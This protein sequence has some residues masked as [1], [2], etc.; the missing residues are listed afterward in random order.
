MSSSVNPQM[1]QMGADA[2]FFY[3]RRCRRWTQMD[4][5]TN[6]TC[7]IEQRPVSRAFSA[8]SEGTNIAGALPQAGNETAPLALNR[9]LSQGPR[10]RWREGQADSP[11]V[12]ANIIFR[13]V[14]LKPVLALNRDLSQGL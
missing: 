6:A 11:G 9:A 7:G 4:L 1:S 14:R 12:R 5:S 8:G 10:R 2:R 3:I 13:V